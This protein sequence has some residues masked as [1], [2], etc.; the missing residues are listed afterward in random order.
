MGM[1]TPAQ[2]AEM[3]TKAKQAVKDARQIAEDTHRM[4]DRARR[5]A[6]EIW[7]M[8]LEIS[9]FKKRAPSEN[10]HDKSD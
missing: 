7:E 8:R 5:A 9:A 2:R 3:L 1:M 10:L 6:L 4:A